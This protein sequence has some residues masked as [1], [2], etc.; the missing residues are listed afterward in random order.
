MKENEDKI[1]PRF[2]GAKG[3]MNI[4]SLGAS[5]S[6]AGLEK[7]FADL[8][9][10]LESGIADGT[11]KTELLAKTLELQSAVGTSSYKE[12]YVDWISMAAKYITVVSPFVPA[13]TGL[14]Q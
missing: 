11:A 1:V 4:Y 7:T 3:Q 13:L 8:R 14:L 2:L 12:R 9:K 6:V 5:I 10:A